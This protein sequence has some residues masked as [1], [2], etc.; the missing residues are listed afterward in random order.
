MSA[1]MVCNGAFWH[2]ERSIGRNIQ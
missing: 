1:V 2:I